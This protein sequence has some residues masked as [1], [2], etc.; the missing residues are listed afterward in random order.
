MWVK[1]QL[2]TGRCVD[3]SNYPLIYNQIYTLKY[4]G[5]SYNDEFVEV[6]INNRTYRC[7]LSRFTNVCRYNENKTIKEYQKELNK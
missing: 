1:G 2:L 7:W 6:V 3:T 4:V 5:Y